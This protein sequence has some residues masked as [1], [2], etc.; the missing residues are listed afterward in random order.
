[1]PK[2]PVT[3]YIN[4]AKDPNEKYQSPTSVAR[5]PD[6]GVISPTISLGS[7]NPEFSSKRPMEPISSRR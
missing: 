1:M 7:I 4:G 3:I 5:T 6:S 2:M